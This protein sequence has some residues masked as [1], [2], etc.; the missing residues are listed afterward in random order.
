MHV[1][2]ICKTFLKG[3]AEKQALI[4]AKLLTER[5]V[6]V[7]LINWHGSKID[8][9]NLNTIKAS[10][11]KYFP[12]KGTVLGKLNMFGKILRQEKI[13][14]VVSYLTLA[15]F[16]SG[17]SR[18]FNKNLLSIGG[19]RNEKLPYYK[20]L[21]E[22]FIHNHLNDAT[23]FNNFSAKEKFASRGF[24][25]DKICVIQNAIEIRDKS[26]EIR[27][28]CNGEIKIITVGRF[29]KQKDYETAL[30]SFRN[31][32]DRD[33]KRKIKYYIVGYGPLEGK[34]RSLA[35]SL[36]ID[37]RIKVFINP[38]E[39]GEILKMSDI[40]LSTSLFEGVSNSIMEAMASGLPIVATN[41][42]DNN[43]LIRDGYNGYLVPVK[44]V[45]SI[46]ERLDSL[47]LSEDARVQFGKNSLNLIE[48][49]FSGGKFVENYL[50]L[51]HKF[52]NH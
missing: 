13:N 31:L 7:Y 24:N 40:F 4:L 14:F 26:G 16:V 22:R 29:V 50:S 23:V 10:T 9:A 41:V 11:Y 48:S 49:C 45:N 36:K 38:P 15:N 18:L 6:K 19:I 37:D 20:F 44:D 43:Y 2:L 46:V 1:A 27:K 32:V 28:N 35:K 21:I 52:N 33:R 5:N 51:F 3:G 47:A 17:F 25:P 8:S 30:N 34:V 12:L 42:G 39:V